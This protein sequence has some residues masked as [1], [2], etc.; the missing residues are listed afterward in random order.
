LA[1]PPLSPPIIGR[2]RES[3]SYSTESRFIG[4]L[5]ESFATQSLH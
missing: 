4:R 3:S 5:N 1:L 2:S